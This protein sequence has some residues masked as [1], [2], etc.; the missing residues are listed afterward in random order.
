MNLFILTKIEVIYL[1][2]FIWFWPKIKNKN[3]WI[4]DDDD[5]DELQ[6]NSI[7]FKKK[8]DLVILNFFNQK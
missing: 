7:R 3:E 2:G 6:F 8:N 4:D 5:D 1:F